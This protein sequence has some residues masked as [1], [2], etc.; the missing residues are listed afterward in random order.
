VVT[1]QIK[2]L[3]KRRLGKRLGALTPPLLAQVERATKNT[4][5]LV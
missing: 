3:D 4:L 1:E 5:A 2:A